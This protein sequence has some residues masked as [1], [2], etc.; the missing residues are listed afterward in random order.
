MWEKY[1][2]I[3]RIKIF[4]FVKQQGVEVFPSHIFNNRNRVKTKVANFFNMDVQTAIE[5]PQENNLYA[6]NSMKRA[7]F[8]AIIELYKLMR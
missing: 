5:I 3:L 8:S 1:I 6:H 2:T 4:N 7:V